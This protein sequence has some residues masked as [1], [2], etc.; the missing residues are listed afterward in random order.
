MKNT[1]CEDIENNNDVFVDYQSG[2]PRGMPDERNTYCILKCRY[3][4]PDYLPFDQIS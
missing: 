3:S 4:N 1:S 2:L